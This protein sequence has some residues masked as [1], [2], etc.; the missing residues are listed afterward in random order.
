MRSDGSPS[1]RQRDARGD[2]R[3]PNVAETARGSAA[4]GWLPSSS[5][6][7]GRLAGFLLKMLH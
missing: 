2:D 3:S 1:F 7:L 5:A 4:C 6:D